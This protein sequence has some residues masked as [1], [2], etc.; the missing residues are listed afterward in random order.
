[1]F[2][3]SNFFCCGGPQLLNTPSSVINSYPSSSHS[4]R[5]DYYSTTGQRNSDVPDLSWPTTVPF[6]PYDIFKL[7]RNAPYSKARY[8]ELVKIYHP[9][10]PCNGHPLCKDISP[11]VRLHRYRLVVSA[12][13]IL[14]DPRRRRVYDQFGAGWNYRTGTS[15][16]PGWVREDMRYHQGPVYANATWEDWEKYYHRGNETRQQHSVDHRTFTTLII[17]L[18][19]F[20]GAV[21]LVMIGQQHTGYEQRIRDVNERS[22]RFLTGRRRTV[23]RTPSNEVRVRE[24]LIHRDPSGCGLKEGEAEVYKEYR[25][26]ARN[27]HLMSTSRRT[28]R[29]DPNEKSINGAETTVKTIDMNRINLAPRT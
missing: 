17:L 21:Q 2:K 10:R 8:Y 4:R 28:A 19:L 20:G 22:A 13:E 11:E 12:H 1:M 15:H 24:F 26:L 16:D 6:T 9:D 29:L 5:V 23:D 14:S 25:D 18:T 3:K 27:D 7:K